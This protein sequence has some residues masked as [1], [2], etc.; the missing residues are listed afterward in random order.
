M[1]RSVRTVSKAKCRVLWQETPVGPPHWHVSRWPLN[2]LTEHPLHRGAIMDLILIMVGLLIEV[3]RM[4]V[5]SPK[6]ECS[7]NYSASGDIVTLDQTPQMCQICGL[8]L[9]PAL[10]INGGEGDPLLTHWQQ[11]PSVAVEVSQERT[12]AKE[13]QLWNSPY[14]C[15]PHLSTARDFPATWLRDLEIRGP[16]WQ[17][18]M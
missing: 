11:G 15:Q 13:R 2:K 5:V 4:G 17:W 8:H 12:E 10:W 7:T 9:A 3:S 18:D 6:V 14:H 1:K 16:D